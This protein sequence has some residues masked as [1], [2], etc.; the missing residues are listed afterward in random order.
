[1]LSSLAGAESC[2]VWQNNLWHW[3]SHMTH[4]PVQYS[5]IKK[6]HE[7]AGHI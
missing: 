4:P 6:S 1:M 7:W 2:N 3:P 5:E